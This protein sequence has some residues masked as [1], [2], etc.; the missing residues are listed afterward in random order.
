MG[1]GLSAIKT[2]AVLCQWD[3]GSGFGVGSGPM[4]LAGNIV[5]ASMWS[6][7]DDEKEIGR[8]PASLEE[9]RE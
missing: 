8:V 4:D 7:E 6:P 3:P 9:E 1:R 2:C 5:V